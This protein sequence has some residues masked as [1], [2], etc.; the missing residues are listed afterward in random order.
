MAVH[1]AS[2]LPVLADQVRRYEARR[3]RRAVSVCIALPPG[4]QA[5]QV[6]RSLARMLGEGRPSP[7]DIEFQEVT[8]G[9]PRVI[10]VDFARGEAR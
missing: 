9:A 1:G 7:P 6:R 3:G 10:T 4:V 5:T 2:L 8:S